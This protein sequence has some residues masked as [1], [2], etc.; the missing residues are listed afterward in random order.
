MKYNEIYNLFYNVY[1]YLYR[2]KIEYYPFY[3]YM[4]TLYHKNLED[5]TVQLLIQNWR[6]KEL[7]N[8]IKFNNIHVIANDKI[9]QNVLACISQRDFFNKKYFVAPSV[10]HV[11][12]DSKNFSFDDFKRLEQFSFDKKYFY[13]VDYDFVG[14]F[15]LYLQMM[16][17]EIVHIVKPTDTAVN[18]KTQLYIEMSMDDNLDDLETCIESHINYRTKKIYVSSPNKKKCFL[19]KYFNVLETYS[20]KY[21]I[22]IMD[23]NFLIGE[24]IGVDETDTLYMKTNTKKIYQSENKSFLDWYMEYMFLNKHCLNCEKDLLCATN[25][26][27]DYCKWKFK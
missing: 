16:N 8:G 18:E 11:Y 21:D 10:L 7:L 1:E 4:K 13:T 6:L 2:N 19:E 9:F 22:P 23:I 17:Y 26:L 20:K 5:E 15:K 12:Y 27:D 14:E 25:T 3:E 24:H